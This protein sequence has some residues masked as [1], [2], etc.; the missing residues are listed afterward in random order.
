MQE[1]KIYA[2]PHATACPKNQCHALR[3]KQSSVS[4]ASGHPGT[5]TSKTSDV[6]HCRSLLTAGHC[7]CK[8]LLMQVTAQRS[9]VVSQLRPVLR[10]STVVASHVLLAIQLVSQVCQPG[11][12]GS[13]WVL[14][15]C[16][17]TLLASSQSQATVQLPSCMRT[18]HIQNSIGQPITCQNEITAWPKHITL[19]NMAGW[20][21][22]QVT[23]C[24]KLLLVAGC[25]VPDQSF[26]TISPLGA[27]AAHPCAIR[28]AIL[29]LIHESMPRWPNPDG[30]CLLHRRIDRDQC[31][32]CT[33]ATVP[34]GGSCGGLL[35][36]MDG[37]TLRVYCGTS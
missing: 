36:I 22:W 26:H 21:L 1:P 24:G 32:Q 33:S 28:G 12:S 18:L 14:K 16:C 10:Q 34:C 20:W 3:R 17:L 5:H 2:T 6:M 23:V 13:S 19:P 31:R 27:T 8:S 4:R 25:L 9:L 7:S 30:P 29:V 11:I 15:T 37:L 35:L